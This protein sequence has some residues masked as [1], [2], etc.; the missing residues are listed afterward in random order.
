MSKRILLLEHNSPVMAPPASW[1]VK[2]VKPTPFSEDLIESY[3][4]ESEDR[5]AKLTESLLQTE[6]LTEE[7]VKTA[8][9]AFKDQF[10]SELREAHQHTRMR[11]SGPAQVENQKN[12]NNR[13]YPTAL[14][15]RVLEDGSDFME[16]LSNRQVLGELEHPAEGNT[17]LPRVSHLV[18]KVWRKEGVVHAQHLIFRTPN[19]QI[20][21]ELYR[22]GAV[23]GVSSRG[24]GSTRSV[25][26]V[27][28]VEANDFHLDTWDFV[29]QPSVV[30]ARPSS[31]GESGSV[32]EPPVVPEKG[33]FE[34]V[35]VN[36]IEPKREDKPMTTAQLVESADAISQGRSALQDSQ[37]YLQSND[38]TLNGLM[39]HQQKVTDA[40]V[41]MGRDFPEDYR[42]QSLELK[43][44]LSEHVNTL[45]REVNR[46]MKE[47]D[48][49]GENGDKGGNGNVPPQFQKGGDNGENGNGDEKKDERLA[50]VL[51]MQV[52][53]VKKLSDAEVIN[54]L[55]ARNEALQQ[56]V[57]DAIPEAK[58]R[59][60]IELGEAIVARS[61]KDKKTYTEAID[62][63]KEEKGKAVK[64]AESS[65][66][67]LE[68]TVTKY[69]TEKVSVVV[70]ALI[71][72]NPRLASVKDRM[73]ECR[74]LKELQSLMEGTIKPLVEGNSSVSRPDLP[75]VTPA[76]NLTEGAG[77][78]GTSPAPPKTQPSGGQSDLMEM[79]VAG[80][81][82]PTQYG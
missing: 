53:D 58:Y 3:I 48:D 19:G 5:Y 52:E 46:V 45:R 31:I 68:A 65:R 33:N 70:E 61:N 41:S 20:V 51:G 11:V 50:S 34:P 35:F 12:G 2:L 22:S 75:P 13:M 30:T 40:L 54:S 39:D 47:Q 82:N 9:A 62:K 73:L 74:D 59:M 24:A 80:E 8:M 36:P 44:K 27:D 37:A 78:N 21:E 26:G 14:W 43:A 23:P 1:S 38:I 32:Q 63:L 69:R 29:A 28:V 17:K 7:Q 25:D 64:L 67:L 71:E 16:R 56:Q 10:A 72:K 49:N 66:A 60:A 42:Q 6:K 57:E 4:A 77:G 18:E 81:N 76:G 79:L 15:D 55:V